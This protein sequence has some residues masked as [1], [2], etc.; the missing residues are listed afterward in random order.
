[1]LVEV[2]IPLDFSPKVYPRQGSRD[3][4]MRVLYKM[5]CDMIVIEG[6]ENYEDI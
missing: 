2:N 3:N 5:I 6:S 1:M 4:H